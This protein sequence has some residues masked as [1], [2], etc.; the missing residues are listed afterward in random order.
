M[1]KIITI[2]I[3]LLSLVFATSCEEED[4]EAPYGD[5]SSFS[6]YSSNEFDESEKV[7]NI[8]DYISY[9]D[10]SRNAVSHKWT[11]PASAKFLNKE[12][13]PNDSIYE[14]FILNNANTSEE[15]GINVLFQK[16]GLQEVKLYNT[17]KDSVAESVKSGDVWVVD[18]TFVVDVYAD[19]NP[20]CKILHNGVEVLRLNASDM[21]TKDNQSS[22]PVYAIEAGDELQ[23]IDLSTI[24]RPTGVQ[25]YVK[26]GAPEKGGADTLAVKYNKLGDFTAW[27]E[28]LRSG[29]TVPKKTISK[30]I[31]LNIKVI[32][33]TKPFVFNGDFINRVSETVLS[34]PVTGEVASVLGQADNFTVHVTNADA[35]YDQD[36]AVQSVVINADDATIIELTLAERVYNSDEVEVSFTGGNITSVDERILENFGPVELKSDFVGV[37]DA[38]FSGYEKPYVSGNLY[39]LANTSGHFAQHN[40]NSVAG[41]LYYWRDE[42]FMKDGNS[43]MKFETPATGIPN[44]ARLQGAGFGALPAIPVGSYKPSVWV[45]LEPGNTMTSIEYNFTTIPETFIFD[46]SGITR[47]TWVKITLPTVVVADEI[48][49]G[50][51]DVNVKNTGQEDAIVQKLWLDNF[52]MLEVEVRQP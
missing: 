45:Y 52:D 27:M 6:W 7:L 31:P 44:L 20:E 13:T 23:Y 11:I 36:I 35:G 42:T 26:G 3:V 48:S 12:F 49:G 32:P 8:N 37:M 5:F 17:Y 14:S 4:Y 9:V 19:L 47:G 28:S 10:L 18:K 29:D 24:G 25:F 1:K 50:R 34:F 51:L 30:L 38:E 39:K 41:P 15:N 2:S 22:W 46:L 16:S 33:S 21:P 43:S 40:G